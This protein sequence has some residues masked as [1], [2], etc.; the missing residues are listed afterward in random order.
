MDKKII[1]LLFTGLFIVL[2]VSLVHAYFDFNSKYIISHR[3]ASFY[4]QENTLEAF[5]KAIEFGTDFVE[6][7]V[8]KTR[9]GKLVAFHDSEIDDMGVGE[10]DYHFLNEQ[11]PY[12]VPTFEQVLIFLQGKTKIHADL[13]EQD[14]ELEVVDQILKYFSVNDFFIS[15]EHE[16][17]LIKIKEINPNI[18]TGIIIKES[19]MGKL[20][21]NKIFSF[22]PFPSFFSRP[23]FSK[24]PRFPKDR[25]ID[26]KADFVV[27]D[28]K[29]ADDD[30]LRAAEKLDKEVF[31][32]NVNDKDLI[33]WFLADNRVKG[34]ITDRPDL[35]YNIS[36]GQ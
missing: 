9:D 21:S 35:V 23:L 33:D 2:F 14:Y 15:S 10:L 25:I 26:S 4:E 28:Y 5:E 7:D 29:V 18:K 30:F 3:G 12:H 16:S 17:S 1:S 6:I 27:S 32:W 22:F 8:R 34:I 11:T 20:A 24:Y 19:K 36:A 31:V 13:K